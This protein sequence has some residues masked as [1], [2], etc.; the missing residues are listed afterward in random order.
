MTVKPGSVSGFCCREVPF[1]V[2]YCVSLHKTK[3]LFIYVFVNMGF[4]NLVSICVHCGDE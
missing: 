3:Y 1:F 2:G 4:T